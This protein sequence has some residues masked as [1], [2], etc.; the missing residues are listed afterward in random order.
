MMEDLAGIVTIPDEHSRGADPC[1]DIV[2]AYWDILRKV[3]VENPNVT[4]RSWFGDTMTIIVYKTAI[5]S[6]IFTK[7]E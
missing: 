7:T 2:Q 1:E 5:I 6:S 4:G 3:L